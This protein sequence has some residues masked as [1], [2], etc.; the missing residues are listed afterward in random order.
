[1][2]LLVLVAICALVAYIGITQSNKQQRSKNATRKSYASAVKAVDI[3]PSPQQPNPSQGVKTACH[4]SGSDL[5]A[6]IT[7]PFPD[8]TLH[9]GDVLAVQQHSHATS[10]EDEKDA[11]EE[12]DLEYGQYGEY[13]V[14]ERTGSAESSTILKIQYIDRNGVKSVRRIRVRRVSFKNDL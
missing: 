14:F 13:V 11:W 1:M 7:G 4:G 3:R 5:A 9:D 6:D 10:W 12:S 8:L 2:A